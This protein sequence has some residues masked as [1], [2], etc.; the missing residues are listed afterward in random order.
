[1]SDVLEGYRRTL[2]GL[3]A[4]IEKKRALRESGAMAASDAARHIN[5]IEQE[6]FEMQDAIRVM[7]RKGS[8]DGVYGYRKRNAQYG[9]GDT[10]DTA[11]F[12]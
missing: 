4:L 9:D 11:D 6:I 5:V 1:M 12:Q 7:E 2:D 3:R 8:D 10:V